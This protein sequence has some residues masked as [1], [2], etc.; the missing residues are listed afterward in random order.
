MVVGKRVAPPAGTTVRIDVPDADQ[1]WTVSV[2]DD[3]RATLV[4]PVDDP[5]ARVTLGA[6]DF[7]VLAG[8]RRRVEATSA[9]VEGDEALARAL[10]DNLAVTP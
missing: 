6:E 5:T 10:L 7:V 1:S 3:H 2:G 4:D 9:T 8:G